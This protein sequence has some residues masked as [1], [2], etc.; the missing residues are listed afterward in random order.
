METETKGRFYGL[1]NKQAAKAWCKEGIEKFKFED[2]KGDMFIAS[3]I[4]HHKAGRTSHRSYMGWEKIKYRTA[5]KLKILANGDIVFV[6]N[7]V[8]GKYHPVTKTFKL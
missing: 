2:I 7:D 4:G 1:P 3:V 6:E 5:F 8:E